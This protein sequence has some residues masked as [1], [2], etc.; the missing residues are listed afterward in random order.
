[1]SKICP[2]SV[3]SPQEARSI[4]QGTVLLRRVEILLPDAQV[5]IV[6]VVFTRVLHIQFLVVYRYRYRPKKASLETQ[7]LIGWP[8]AVAQETGWAMWSWATN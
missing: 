3:L 8:R 2:K 7:T 5:H 4:E 1:M 6:E